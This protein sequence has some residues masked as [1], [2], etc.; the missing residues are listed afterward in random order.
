MRAVVWNYQGL[1]NTLIIRALKKMMQV[2]VPIIVFLIET[3]LKSREVEIMKSELGLLNDLS[4]VCDSISNG[5]KG[6]LCL[7]WSDRWNV[8]LP[9][10]S[11]NHIDVIIEEARMKWRFTSIY[12]R[13]DDVNK[14][15]T[16]SLLRILKESAH[17]SLMCVGNFNEVV[18]GHEK[19]RGNT[20]KASDLQNFHET[21]LDYGLLNTGFEGYKYI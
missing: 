16:W 14:S 1:G 3:R 17:Y 2:K 19:K 11:L 9:S 10:N 21:I 5:R 6:G 4:N 13:L 15:K 20:C 12:G 8:S 18:F 7:F